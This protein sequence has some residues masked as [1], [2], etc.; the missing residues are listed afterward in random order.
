M[1]SAT[2]PGT[3]SPRSPSLTARAS[4]FSTPNR[5]C[6]DVE[7]D[8]D[9]DTILV[10][11]DG[12]QIVGVSA[13]VPFEMTLPGNARVDVTGLTFVSVEVTHRRRG[14]MRAMMEQQVRDC[15][16]RGSVA[17]ILTASE[18]GIY[19][20]FGYGVATTARKIAIERAAARYPQPVREHGVVRMITADARP[21]LAPI[22]DRWRRQTPGGLDRNERRWELQL[23][24]RDYQRHGMSEL[25]HLV[26]ADGYLSYRVR[27]G[28]NDVGVYNVASVVDYAPCTP[29]AHAALWQVLL[30]MDLCG[31]IESSRIPL[32]D[33][34][35]LP[36]HRPAP[37]H[38]DISGRRTVGA[39]ARRV[40]AAL[41][42]PICR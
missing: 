8:I 14:I 40:R 30:G 35:P 5:S 20:R 16:R 23:L 34:L 22:Y 31:Q 10:A 19:P 18:G 38:H 32:D 2:R 41:R 28:S 9:L 42:A 17:M 25:F 11:R 33:P 12:Q 6:A 37:G 4:A 15:A 21:L 13:E 36:A 26:H 29:E 1:R 3:S 27:T 7:L 24:D 39:A